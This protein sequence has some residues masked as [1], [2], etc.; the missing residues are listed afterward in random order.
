MFQQAFQ[1]PFLL[2]LLFF[3]DY[4]HGWFVLEYLAKLYWPKTCLK[5]ETV[6]FVLLS[7]PFFIFSQ[8]PPSLPLSWSQIPLAV[9]EPSSSWLQRRMRE[10][11]R[12]VRR[13]AAKL[14]CFFWF[15]LLFGAGAL[16][17][18]IHLEDLSEMVQRQEPGEYWQN[19]SELYCQSNRATSSYTDDWNCVVPN[20]PNVQVI[21]HFNIWHTRAN[22][23]PQV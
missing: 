20:T 14:P 7:S 23:H 18:F 17:L 5:S 15:V 19:Q 21:Q 4:F 22:R 13:M 1:F 16:V 8:C 6:P 11:V 12:V 10:S 9:A 3:K 2:R